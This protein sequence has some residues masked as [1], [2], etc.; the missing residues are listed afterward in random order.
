MAK[1][2][3]SH[4]IG[5]ELTKEAGIPVAK[6]VKRGCTPDAYWVKGWYARD[7]GKFY[8]EWD[9]KDAQSVRQVLKTTAPEFPI[10]GIYEMEKDM[11]FIG[12]DYR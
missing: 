6:A 10:E 3:V 8:C 11:I 9:A 4:P 7:E 12:E 1:F 5:K 2:L